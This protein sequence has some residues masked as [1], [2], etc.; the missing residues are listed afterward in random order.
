MTRL[1]DK[2]IAEMNKLP[3]E[4]QNAIAQLVLDELNDEQLWDQA[5]GA[6][7]EKPGKLA[8]EVR[9]DIQAGVSSTWG[10]TICEIQ[11]D[12]RLPEI[13]REAARFSQTTSSQ[14]LY[15]WKQ[16]P[17]YPSLHF[18]QVQTR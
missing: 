2:A 13:F 9:Q 7:Q 15:I 4:K 17:H 6:P 10:L 18:K 3:A 8:A 12:G 5:F 16:D 11:P 14:E 1:L